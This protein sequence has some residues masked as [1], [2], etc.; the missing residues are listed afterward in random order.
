MKKIII[1]FDC[2]GTLI[3]TEP[4]GQC[5]YIPN[6]RIVNLLKILYTFK[7]VKIIVWSGGGKDHA[8]RTVEELELKKYIKGIYDKADCDLDVDIAIDDQHSF[9]LGKLN[10]IVKEK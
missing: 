5:N 4:Y 1:A 6:H 3:K 2:D 8:E 7:N 10:L 9:N